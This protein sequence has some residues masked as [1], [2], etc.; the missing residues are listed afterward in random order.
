MS[1][2]MYGFFTEIIRKIY[3][4][5]AI[6]LAVKRLFWLQVFSIW[7]NSLHLLGSLSA[8]IYNW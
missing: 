2:T 7:I 6:K 4:W 5:A 8:Y 1:I 3:S